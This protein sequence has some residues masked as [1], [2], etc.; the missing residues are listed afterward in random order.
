MGQQ[1]RDLRVAVKD[2]LE[3]LDLALQ[4]RSQLAAGAQRNA[5]DIVDGLVGIERNALPAHLRQAIAQL[6][7]HA[8]Q[9][10]LECCKHADRA[11]T[12]NQRIDRLR[13]GFIKLG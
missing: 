5:G 11:C 2:G 1:L 3:G 6:G 9:T 7:L 12:H 10:Q 8:L 13:L 4:L